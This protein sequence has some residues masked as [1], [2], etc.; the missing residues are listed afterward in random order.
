LQ[1]AQEFD[2]HVHRQV[3]DLIEEQ[4]AALG[5]FEP[6]CLAAGGA[7]ESAFLVAEQLAFH[8]GFGE[9]AA[10]DCDEGLV[11]PLAQVVDVPRHQFF[12]GATLAN[13]IHR[14]CRPSRMN[15]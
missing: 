4:R 12:A 8:Q 3:A 7:G 2:L 10:V 5:R 11:A 9:R 6:A 13:A 1:H 15:C 14:A